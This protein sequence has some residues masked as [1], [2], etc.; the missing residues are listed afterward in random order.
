[1]DKGKSFFL[2][3]LGKYFS[4]QFKGEKFNSGLLKSILIP[5]KIA[6]YIRFLADSSREVFSLITEK[7]VKF[8]AFVREILG[9]S[10]VTVKILQRLAGKCV[11]SPSSPGCKAVY[12]RNECCDFSGPAF[13][14][15]DFD[16]WCPSR[17]YLPLAIFRILG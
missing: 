8:I 5:S 3:V 17:G 7:K 9:N 4:G 11:S 1:M 15:G 2:S 12:E 13:S 10:Y 14:K 6:P 16:A